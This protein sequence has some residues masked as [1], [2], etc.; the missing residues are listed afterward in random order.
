[1]FAQVMEL[2]ED[3]IGLHLQHLRAGGYAATT[4][5]DA[6]ELLRR[7]NR[8]LPSGLGCAT[9]EELAAWLAHDGWSKQTRVT[10][11]LILV[12]FFEWA[13]QGP[14]PYLDLNPAAFLPRPRVPRT[15]PRPATDLQAGAA[16]TVK[17]QPWR[18]H[19]LLAGYAGM[20]SYEI[21]RVR[22]EHIDADTVHIIGGKGGMDRDV[23]TH[24]ALWEAVTALPAGPLSRM[25]N[26]TTATARWVSR[27]TAQHLH[28]K[29]IPISLHQLRH[30]FATTLLRQGRDIREIQELLGHASLNSTAIYTEVSSERKRAAVLSLPRLGGAEVQPDRHPLATVLLRAGV[31]IHIVQELMRHIDDVPAA[32]LASRDLPGDNWQVPAA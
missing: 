28:L 17:A 14:A 7:V 6:G 30:W 31:G 15:L 24:P 19:C 32:L 20:R 26:G 10:Y 21:A 29:G 13:T 1:M 25:R 22:R 8:D 3:L 9:R 16:F 18:L 4:I 11:R 12:R 27:C 2:S 23:P 5:D